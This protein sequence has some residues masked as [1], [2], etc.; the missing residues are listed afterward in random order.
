MASNDLRDELLC[1][2]CCSTYTDPVMLK[3]GHNF[4][5][6]CIDR[7]L[8]KPNRSGVYSCPECRKRYRQR[9]ELMKNFPLRNILENFKSAQPTQ[10]QTGI[11]C[12][13][14]VES[15]VPAVKSC[16]HCE[17]S[18]CD[19]HLKVHCK[20]PEHV[21]CDPSTNLDKRKCS[22]HKKIL[23]YYCT[24]DAACIC[25]YCLA[26]QH[27][28]HQVETLDE[29]S[30]KKKEKLGSVLQKLTK[31]RWEIKKKVHNLEQSR[32]KAQQNTTASV[33]R[34]NAVF[35]DIKRHLGKKKER[36]LSEISKQKMDE[37]LKVFTL[38]QIQEKKKD[39]LCRK[40]RRI[41]ELC[42]RTDPLS[43]L[44]EPD[45]GDFCDPEEGG[46]DEDTG[47]H[48]RQRHDVDDLDVAVISD[49]IQKLSDIIT[50][51]RSG[52]Y[53]EDPGD[54]LLDVNTA[55]NYLHISDDLKTATLTEEEQNRPETAERFQDYSQVISIRGFTSGRH[56]WD[57]EVISGQKKRL[58]PSLPKPSIEVKVTT[59]ASND[60]RDEL[61]CSICCSTYTDPVML[62]CG[63]NFCQICIDRV[64]DKPN[65]SGIYS[66]PECRKKYQQRPILMKNIALRNILE[67]FKS[68]Q[69]TQ[70]QTGIFCTYC[71]DS[72]VPSVKSCLHC[73]TSPCDKHLKVHCKTPEHVLCD[74]STNLDKRK[75]SVHKKI[76]EYY[77]TEDAACICAYCLAEQ[78][79][80]HQVEM[81]DEASEKKKEKLGSILQ[82]LTKNRW[83]IKKKV[84]NLEHSRDIAQQNTTASVMRVN[85]VFADIKRHLGKKKERILSE[86]SKQKMDETLKVFTLTQIQEKKKDELCRKMRRIEE[87]CNRTDP[88]SVLK[89]PDTGDL[90]DP[91]EGGGDEDTRGHDRQRHDVDDLDVAVISDRIQKLSDIITDIRSGIYVEDPGDILLDLN[92]AS[93]DI[94][95]S[96]D[97]KTATGT[98][99]EQ[100]RPETAERFQYSQ[101]ISIRRFSS[102]RH[103]WDVKGSRSGGW[104]VGMCYPSMARRGEN[105]C[106]GDNNKSW[107]LDCFMDEFSVSHNSIR[108]LLPKELFS[109]S[110]KVRICL[111]YEAGRLSF[112]E[113]CDPIRHL[114][115]FTA[116]FTEPLHAAI[117]VLNSSLRLLGAGRN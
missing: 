81:L 40:M 72:P 39:E 23:E 54:I 98:E 94:Y 103:Y 35:A 104:S 49:R 38:T 86:I 4:C 109:Y 99:K 64:L 74:P 9:P 2:I 42:N 89:D 15:P 113:L 112:Y 11:F 88:L 67:N 101:V 79:Q 108:R 65:R 57:V 76:L 53:V 92:T 21:L 84:H 14:C 62:K 34:V 111:D 32:D 5:Q 97:L 51:I 12:T 28:G 16:L 41:E 52:I 29:A 110:Y 33:M 36:I 70:T 117:Y 75:C 45:T 22:V 47:G 63:H 91:E 17:T 1:S 102:G 60:L 80:G 18:P 3:C 46:G 7:V 6:I 105:S 69:P 31:N 78:H 95:I 61:L 50:D 85:A 37:T 56:Y 82:R 44:Q 48:Y 19:K 20:T 8:D 71:V 68:A 66:C 116:I 106:I 107:S 24:E 114:Y 55:N 83:E 10:T 96:D 13:Y 59:M 26:E 25:A 100:N 30:E 77:C 90:C 87:L 58:A 73:E 93:T 43:V 27:Q 115:T